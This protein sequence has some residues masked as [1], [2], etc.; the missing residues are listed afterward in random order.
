M[1]RLLILAAILASVLSFGQSGPTLKE[2]TDWIHNFT[3]QHGGYELSLP[4]YSANSI[5]HIAF[6]GCA[7][8]V[9]NETS[10]TMNNYAGETPKKET[11]KEIFS[12]QFSL[13]DIDPDVEEGNM[14]A[15]S[16]T[17]MLRTRDDAPLIHYGKSL[18]TAYEMT[19]DTEEG[20]QRLIRVVH[21]A[22]ILCGGKPSTF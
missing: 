6:K 9:A 16:Y 18:G 20:A 5:D 11:K 15:H 14:D 21:H 8:T 2:T 10:V 3:E 4:S 19:A 17:V 7:A 22:V 13:A 12:V 1:K